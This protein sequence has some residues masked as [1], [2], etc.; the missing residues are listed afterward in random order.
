ML[1]LLTIELTKSGEWVET[2]VK[3]SATS[4]GLK[5]SINSY[6]KNKKDIVAVV[7]GERL[8][9]YKIPR[10]YDCPEIR[11][12]FQGYNDAQMPTLH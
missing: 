11:T 5:P 2:L 10:Q 6:L 9:T 7:D 8:L 3:E 4:A 12:I 1:K